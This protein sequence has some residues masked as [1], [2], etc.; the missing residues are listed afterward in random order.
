VHVAYDTGGRRTSTTEPITATTTATTVFG[1]DDEGQLTS[2]TDPLHTPGTQDHTTLYAYDPSGNLVSVKDANNHETKYEYDLLGRKTKR[3]LPL[4]TNVSETF[5]YTMRPVVNA[6]TDFRGKTTTMTYDM[7]ARLLARIPDPSLGEPTE[8]YT[9]TATGA[10]ARMTDASGTTS[11][12]YDQRDRVLT[13]TTPA[14]TLTYTYDATGNVATVRSSNTNGTSIDYTWDAANQLASVT[15]NRLGGIT[16]PAFTTTGQ[17]SGLVYPNG[18]NATYAYDNLNQVTSI[19]WSRG[20]DPAFAR[21]SYTYNQR[22]QRLTSTNQVSGRKATYGYDALSR[23][24]NETISNDPRGAIGDGAL[25]YTLDAVGN[26]V[27]RTSTLAAL[28]SQNFTNGYDA[29]DELVAT[30]GYDANGNTIRSGSATYAYDFAN[31]LVSRNNGAVSLVYGCDGDRVAKSVSGV[32]TR[33][34]VDDLN[35]TGYLQVL[36]EVVG[37]A[38]Q[39]RYTYARSIVSQTKLSGNVPATTFYGYDAHGNVT[40]L[41]DATGLVTDTYDYDAWGNLVGGTATTPNTRLF[42]GQELDPDLGLLN[43]RARS[44]APAVGRFSTRDPAQGEPLRP[45]SLNTYLFAES[46]PVDLWDPSGLS[47]AAQDIA[48]I[49]NGITLQN[50]VARNVL[51][52]TAIAA[53]SIGFFGNG[54]SRTKAA[55]SAIATTAGTYSAATAF[56]IKTNQPVAIGDF[57]VGATIVCEMM[58]TTIYN[59]GGDPGGLPKW[60]FPCVAW[61]PFFS[62][63]M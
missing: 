20:N 47:A 24:T 37:G 51:N 16:T 34:L 30:D 28:A 12:T 11:Y 59:F 50:I 36:E 46:D 39:A 53:G 26:R 56:V 52:A 63:A 60:A 1:Y 48:L 55:F 43:L 57:G 3:T 38:V 25:T 31:R 32:T 4:N 8:S 23:L 45:A 54:D 13:K 29:N 18:V 61:N 41:T 6:H 7:R 40:F 2:V 15:D 14:G 27:T 35:P 62:P 33:Y 49:Q 5:A 22:G 10:R 17:P 21:W 19:A 58:V 42:G 44:Y 9:Y